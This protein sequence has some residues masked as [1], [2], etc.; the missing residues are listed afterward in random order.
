[1]GVASH[2]HPFFPH[3]TY[4]SGPLTRRLD[5]FAQRNLEIFHLVEIHISDGLRK[6]LR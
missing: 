5:P 1:M 2:Q 4:S 6:S 3:L